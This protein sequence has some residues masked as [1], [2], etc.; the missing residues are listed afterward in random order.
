MMPSSAAKKSTMQ[1][2]VPGTT[3]EVK[4]EEVRKEV[5]VIPEDALSSLAG[6][7]LE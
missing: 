6:L 2:A 7:H 3:S 4:V 1:S 5:E